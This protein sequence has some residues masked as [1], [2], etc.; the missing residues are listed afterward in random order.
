MHVHEKMPLV[1]TNKLP[2]GYLLHA[3]DYSQVKVL[4]FGAQKASRKK[5]SCPA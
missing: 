2:L 1:R 5:R 3:A 4:L